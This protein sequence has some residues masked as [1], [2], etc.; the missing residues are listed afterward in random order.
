MV[1]I[2]FLWSFHSRHTGCFRTDRKRGGPVSAELATH[3][4]GSQAVGNALHPYAWATSVD[5]NATV[6][7]QTVDA[8]ANFLD[9]VEDGESIVALMG[10]FEARRD[11]RHR[12]RAAW[13]SIRCELSLVIKPHMLAAERPLLRPVAVARLTSPKGQTRL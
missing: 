12:P 11:A 4:A 6:A 13:S 1:K 2:I 3:R 9:V 8:D 10:H 5:G 7:G